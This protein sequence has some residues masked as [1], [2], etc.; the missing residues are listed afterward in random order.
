[1]PFRIGLACVCVLVAACDG[2]LVPCDPDAGA[3]DGGDADAGPACFPGFEDPDTLRCRTKCTHVAECTQTAVAENCVD[4]CLTIIQTADLTGEP[5]QR[6]LY[7][8]EGTTPCD[9]LPT[10]SVP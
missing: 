10:C 8:C 1:M 4:S 7:D 6:P 9:L 5:D 3:L 2:L